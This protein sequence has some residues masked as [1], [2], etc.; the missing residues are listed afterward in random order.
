MSRNNVSVNA[1]HA[2]ATA[3]AFDARVKRPIEVVGPDP[4]VIG[5]RSLLSAA[6]SAGRTA[7]ADAKGTRARELRLAGQ[8]RKQIAYTMAREDGR[9]DESGEVR[10][11][12]LTQ[13]GRWLKRPPK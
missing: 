2:S 10:E 6:A 8:T 7:K 3:Q 1:G 9:V 13:I 4:E 12:D 5:P 11:Y